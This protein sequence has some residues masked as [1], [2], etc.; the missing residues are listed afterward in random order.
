MPGLELST[1]SPSSTPFCAVAATEVAEPVSFAVTSTGAVDGSGRTTPVAPAGALPNGKLWPLCRVSVVSGS[2]CARNADQT[3]SPAAVPYLARAAT[4]TSADCISAPPPPPNS[5]PITPE[6]A[7]RSVMVKS[8]G[9]PA[10]VIASRCPVRTYSPGQLR[11]AMQR[12]M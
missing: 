7:T 5:P 12:S 1:S 8:T 4:R 2:F 6:I 3:W 10:L 9:P 11:S